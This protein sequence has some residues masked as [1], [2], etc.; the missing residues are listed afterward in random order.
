MGIN[1]GDY[2][3]TRLIFEKNTPKISIRATRDTN[4]PAVAEQSRALQPNQLGAIARAAARSVLRAGSTDPIQ[5]KIFC[6]TH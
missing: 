2:S 5:L 6:L 4:A 1:H 3:R